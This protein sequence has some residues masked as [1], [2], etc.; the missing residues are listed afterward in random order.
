MNSANSTVNATNKENN[1]TSKALQV[2][3]GRGAQN[4][5]LVLSSSSYALR[6][7]HSKYPLINIPDIDRMMNKQFMHRTPEIVLADN[8][9]RFRHATP[10]RGSSCNDMA[11]ASQRRKS[12]DMHAVL[13]VRA[14]NR[15]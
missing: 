7:Q 12:N 4:W 11:L 1:G 5:E 6:R 10:L 15:V 2:R 3:R 13:L 8:T 14:P 9:H